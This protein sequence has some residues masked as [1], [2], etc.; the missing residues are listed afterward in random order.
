[1]FSERPRRIQELKIK[2]RN[3]NRCSCTFKFAMYITQKTK[4]QHL[5]AYYKL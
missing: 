3:S 1:M 5:G 4:A 2:G